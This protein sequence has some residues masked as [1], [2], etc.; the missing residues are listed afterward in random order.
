ME[1]KPMKSKEQ[2]AEEITNK[3]AAL[4]VKTSHYLDKN[5]IAQFQ[6]AI[7]NLYRALVTL[8]TS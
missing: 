1:A 5:T 6:I 7:S 4:E 8:Y 2:L 3:I